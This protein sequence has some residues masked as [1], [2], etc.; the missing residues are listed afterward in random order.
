[1]QVCILKDNTSSDWRT[2]NNKTLKSIVTKEQ[3]DNME[4]KVKE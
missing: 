3:M 2:I 4:Y 1:M